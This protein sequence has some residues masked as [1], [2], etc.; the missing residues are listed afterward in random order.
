[1]ADRDGNRILWGW[2]P[3]TR[4]EE[5]YS[6]AG[7]AGVM[8]LPRVLSLNAEH[9]L[10]MEVAPPVQQLRRSHTG[11]SDPEFRAPEGS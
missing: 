5:E 4:P 9:E 8:S 11:F 10:K 7:W 6:V 2:I 1:M 3:E